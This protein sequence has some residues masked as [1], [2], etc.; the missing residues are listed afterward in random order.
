M[1]K[2]VASVICCAAALVMLLSGCADPRI[3]NTGRNAIEQMLLTTAVDRSV[4]KLD[5][6]MLEGEK[7]RIDYSNLATQTEKNY[8][9]GVLEAHLSAAGAIIALKADEAKYVLRPV[10]ATLATED[11]KIMFGTPSLPI[12]V[13]D[14]SFSLVIAELPLFKRINR[15]GVCKLSVEILEAAT[16]KQ[17]R[18]VGPAVSSSITTDWVIL[19]FPFVTRDFEMGDHGP[20]KFYFF[21]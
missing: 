13:P 7:I 14:V 15:Y 12:P 3:T 6:R 11:N 5:F 20:L 9:Q 2:T 19:F 17:A 4:S 16:N 21:E 10:C 8:V 18:I 1:K